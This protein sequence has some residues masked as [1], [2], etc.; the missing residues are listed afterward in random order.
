MSAILE[1]QKILGIVEILRS[2]EI[3]NISKIPRLPKT[4]TVSM[5][6]KV[7]KDSKGFENFTFQR[8]LKI[9]RFRVSRESKDSG[10]PGNLKILEFPDVTV[11]QEALISLDFIENLDILE[12]VLAFESSDSSDFRDSNNARDSQR[13]IYRF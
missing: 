11:I 13:R 6:S 12:I 3:V 9:S 7:S 1:N 8:F 4:L 10:F 5:D 2:P